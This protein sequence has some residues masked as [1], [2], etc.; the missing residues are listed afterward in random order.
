MLQ[1]ETLSV[2][3]KMYFQRVQGIKENEVY[4]ENEQRGRLTLVFHTFSKLVTSIH[5]NIERPYNLNIINYSV[6]CSEIKKIQ[7]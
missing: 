3:G 6:K 7:S 4:K 2:T 5:M 1:T